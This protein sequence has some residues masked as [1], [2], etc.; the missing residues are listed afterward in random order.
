[1]AD[2]LRTVAQR[3]TSANIRSWCLTRARSLEGLIDVS[4]LYRHR[5]H[6]KQILAAPPD[7]TLHLLRVLLDPGQAEDIDLHIAWNFGGAA[8]T[9]LH[10]R[11]CVACPTDGEGA[12]SVISGDLDAWANVLTG[13][14]TFAAALTSGQ[15]TI[16]GDEPATRRALACFDV[17]GF[18]A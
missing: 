7:R 18:R 3:T 1:M 16:D 10:I 17:E 5:F 15:L 8:R 2:T 13:A 11:N 6:R 12:T 14:Q 9:G 4:R